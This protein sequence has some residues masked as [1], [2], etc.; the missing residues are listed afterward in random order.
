LDSNKDGVPDNFLPDCDTNEQVLE[1]R[2]RAPDLEIIEVT[3]GATKGSIGDMLSVSVKIV[4]RGNAHATDVNVI[5]CKDQSTSDIKKN[6]CDEVNIVYRQIIKA[7][8]PIGDGGLENP[9]SITLLY[10]VEAGNHDV[11][12]DSNNDIVET[13]ETNNIMKIP[14]G[15]MSSNLGAG[16]VVVDV[17]VRYSVPTIILGATFSLIGVAGFVMYGRRIEALQSFA[18]KTSLMSKSDEDDI[19][20]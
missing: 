5:L 20:F 1:L 18:E 8:M 16:D 3:T 17:I 4:N 12:V 14:G 9:D 10:M 15:E 11:V 2:L 19:R 7:I 13:D 6:G